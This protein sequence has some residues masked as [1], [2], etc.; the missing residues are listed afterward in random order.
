MTRRINLPQFLLVGTA[1]AGTTSIA[2]Y[3]KSHPAIN[4]PQKET[5]FFCNQEIV[6]ELPYP[7]QRN[8]RTVV[9]NF[10][11]YLTLYNNN[12]ST[13]L[14]G[15]IGTAYLYYFEH[16][17]PL[18][19]T[20][21][22]TNIKIIIVLR[23]PIE[24]A[25]SSYLHFVKDGFEKSDFATSLMAEEQRIKENWDFMWHHKKIGLYHDQVKAYLNSFENVNI[26]YYDDMKQRP[27][28]FIKKLCSI[29]EI[30]FLPDLQMESKNPSGLPRFRA[31]QQLLTHNGPIKQ[32]LRPFVRSVWGPEKRNQIKKRMKSQNLIDAPEMNKNDKYKL[33]EYYRTDIKKL[34]AL[35]DV[36]LNYWLQ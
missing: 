26:L 35:L 28:Y 14:S 15:E 8:E 25:Y 11:E 30:D 21:L 10:S 5:F 9:R 1:K 34:E 33:I 16:S 32:V 2:S 23:N 36:D 20:Y 7:M 31:L 6:T 12:N 27:E 29:L 19:K 18:I 13:L 3:L 24:R 22:G 4:L 17:I